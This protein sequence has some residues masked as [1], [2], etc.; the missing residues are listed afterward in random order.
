M[1]D[2]EVCSARF[3]LAYFDVTLRHSVPG[4]H[5]R[6]AVASDN[7]GSVAK[8]AEGDKRRRP[9]WAPTFLRGALR[10]GNLR[11][12]LENYHEALA[13]ARMRAVLAA[14]GTRATACRTARQIGVCQVVVAAVGGVSGHGGQTGGAAHLAVS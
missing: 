4:D 3:P 13:R 9:R 14:G 8:E 2:L 1:L 6:L 12:L 10:G 11:P 5:A 7:D